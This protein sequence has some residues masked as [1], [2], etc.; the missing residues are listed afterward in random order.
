MMGYVD[1]SRPVCDRIGIGVPPEVG[2]RYL[3]FGLFF[4]LRCALKEAQTRY[5]AN[6][7]VAKGEG[8]S[9][10]AHINRR[11]HHKKQRLG[12]NS[13]TIREYSPLT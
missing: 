2:Q 4:C 10:P 12:V 5:D 9:E 13:V 3:V 11:S 1:H 7:P 8:L 6:L